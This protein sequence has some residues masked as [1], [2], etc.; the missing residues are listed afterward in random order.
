MHR[1]NESPNNST[2]TTKLD[3]DMDDDLDGAGGDDGGSFLRMRR[4]Y[5]SFVVQKDNKTGKEKRLFGKRK[6]FNVG[7]SGLAPSREET[8]AC[9]AISWKDDIIFCNQVDI[10]RFP[11]GSGTPE[12]VESTL[13][14]PSSKS[15]NLYPAS[16]FNSNNQPIGNSNLLM[17]TGS[18]VLKKI[19]FPSGIGFVP[20][21]T[22]TLIDLGNFVKDP[23]TEEK[24][25]RTDSIMARRDSSTAEPQRSCYLKTFNEQLHAFFVSSTSGYFHLKCDGDP[26]NSNNWDNITKNMSEDFRRFD[27]DIYGYHDTFRNSLYVMHVPK[28]EI[29]MWGCVGTQKGAG[30]FVINELN[31]NLNW[32]EIYRGGAG[33]PSIGLVPY[34][35]LGIYATAPSGGNPEIIASTDYALINYKL[36]SPFTINV[37]VE[38]EFSINNGLTWDSARRFRN[39]DDLQFPGDGKENLE[40]SFF[41]TNHTFYWDHVTDLGLNSQEK[42]ILIRIRPKVVR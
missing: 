36:H 32:R 4:A 2:W 23:D 29:A 21:G 3:W 40:A 19:N 8:H 22:T 33:E 20:S 38:I 24:L 5:K 41:G 7:T 26:S 28:G 31:T 35:N 18:G 11:G 15:L 39:Y 12:I 30:G 25:V 16:G 13:D 14:V 27:G 1:I 6:K 9:D 37:N 42:N 34:D 10:V 17:L